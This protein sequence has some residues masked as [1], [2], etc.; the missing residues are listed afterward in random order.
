MNSSINFKTYLLNEIESQANLSAMKYRCG[1]YS[2]ACAYFHSAE[3]YGEMYG[4]F[5]A[6]E[7]ENAEFEY[8]EIMQ[9]V[10]KRWDVDYRT[11]FDAMCRNV[12][13]YN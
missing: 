2:G 10:C 1:H 4:V 8:I 7:N 5:F 3:Q 13:C 9:K 11:W 6:D 12:Y